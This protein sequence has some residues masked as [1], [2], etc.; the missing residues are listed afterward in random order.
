MLYH[1]DVGAIFVLF[2]SLLRLLIAKIG[3]LA[4][5]CPWEAM[6]AIMGMWKY[7]YSP[8]D[9]RQQRMWRSRREEVGNEARMAK[10]TWNA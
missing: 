8:T 6:L 9:G 7:I 5:S 1:G 4:W 3:P 10:A 2:L